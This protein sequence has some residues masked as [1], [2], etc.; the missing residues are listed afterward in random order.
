MNISDGDFENFLRDFRP[1]QPRALSGSPGERTWQWR[2]LAAAAAVAITCGGAVWFVSPRVVPPQVQPA[3]PREVEN[4]SETLVARPA[5]VFGLQRLALENPG[6]FDAE[7]MAISQTMLPRFSESRS[8]L[9][10]L[11]K[12]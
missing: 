4:V 7:L 2:R 9:R 8:L 12:D 5:S 1:R 10:I 3:Q 6:K 11:A